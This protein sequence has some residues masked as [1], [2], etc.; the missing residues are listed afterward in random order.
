MNIYARVWSSDGW[1]ELHLNY[2]DQV[3]LLNL[4]NK[5]IP[6]GLVQINPKIG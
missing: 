1:R 6:E 3:N 5:N 2:I 4:K